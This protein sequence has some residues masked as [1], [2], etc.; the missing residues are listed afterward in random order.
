MSVLFPVFC[1]AGLK[2]DTSVPLSIFKD[3][4][5]DDGDILSDGDGL[6]A[7]TASTDTE[8]ESETVINDA[9][10]VD[11]DNATN[12][13]SKKFHLQKF[14]PQMLKFIQND[15]NRNYDDLAEAISLFAIPHGCA[16]ATS[17]EVVVG[18]GQK[19]RF[20]HFVSFFLF[21]FFCLLHSAH[22]I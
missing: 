17:E 1:V 6:N 22:A 14:K 2:D 3:V 16:F 4:Y 13:K 5:N 15:T 8:S 7:S 9:L 12:D 19:Y 20:N 10:Y 18:S 21:P 11:E